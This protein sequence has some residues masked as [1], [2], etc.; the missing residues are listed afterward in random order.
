MKIYYKHGGKFIGKYITSFK[1]R[2]GKEYDEQGRL[3][4]EGEYINDI[5]M[6]G[7]KKEYN[8][9][10][11]LVFEGEYFNGEKNGHGKEYLNGK[12]IYEGE[13]LIGERK[14]TI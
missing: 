14:K 6:N 11:E 7:Y 3:I 4:F 1:N 13:Y 12:V 5:P 10:G 9:K 8:D 2:K